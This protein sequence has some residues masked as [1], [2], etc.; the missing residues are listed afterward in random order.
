[1]TE[2]ALEQIGVL[3]SLAFVMELG[4]IQ[5]IKSAIQAGLGLAFLSRLAVLEECQSGRLVE[6]PIEQ[7]EIVRPLQIVKRAERYPKFA[8]KEFLDLVMAHRN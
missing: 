2:R 7:F 6:V 3:P 8:V 1:M 5:A 4:S